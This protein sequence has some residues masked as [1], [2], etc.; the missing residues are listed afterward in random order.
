VPPVRSFDFLAVL[1]GD[2]RLA[3]RVYNQSLSRLTRL[4]RRHAP[5]L[6]LDLHEEIVQETWQLVLARGKESFIA[7]AVEPEAYLSQV[8]RNAVEGVRSN[9]RPA[10]TASRSHPADVREAIVDEQPEKAD[11]WESERQF[12]SEERAMEIRLDIELF[13]AKAQPPVAAALTAML[14][15]G[16]T[17]TEAACDV[18]LTRQTLGRRLQPLRQAA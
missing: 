5:D 17:M 7:A 15:R 9:N 11:S 12:K 2:D 14:I 6:P 18:G 4:A 8:L 13:A 10:G 3:S 16:L 1:G